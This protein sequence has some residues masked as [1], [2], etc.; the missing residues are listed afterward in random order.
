M[1]KH[2]LLLAAFGFVV[3]LGVA[4][5]VT[6]GNA[7]AEVRTWDGGGVDNNFA[8]AANWSDNTA[9]VNGDSIVLPYGV[10][11]SGC[12]GSTNYTLNNDLNASNVT[13]AGI[14]TTGNKPEGC[15]GN[16][17][18]DGN[19]VKVSGNIVGNSGGPY[20]FPWL[21]INAPIT[22]TSNLTIITV[23][24]DSSL[25]IGGNTVTLTNSSFE[26]GASGTGTLT[27]ASNLTGGAGGGCSD[28]AFSYPFGGDSSGFSGSVV[29]NSGGSLSVTSNA[30]DLA[31]AA[32]SITVN[33]GGWLW[34]GAS[35]GESYTFNK[36]ITFNGGNLGASQYTCGESSNTT[37]TLTGTLTLNQNIEVSLYRTN[38]HVT[39]TDGSGSLSMMPGLTG[40]AVLILP[41]GQQLT[42]PVET[43]VIDDSNKSS[44][45]F[46]PQGFTSAVPKNHRYVVNITCDG[47]ATTSTLVDGILAGNG[48]MTRSVLIRSGGTISPGQSP[49]T[50]TVGWLSFEEGGT[51]EFEVLSAEPGQYDQVVANGGVVLGNGTLNTVL[52]EGYNLSA[53]QQ[54]VIIN[55]TSS[56]PVDGTFK[57]L[58]EGANFEVDGVLFS[59]SYVG[60]DGNDVV[61]T[62]VNAPDAPDTGFALLANNPVAVLGASTV[63][64]GAILFIAR[65]YGLLA[66]I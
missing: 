64:A 6:S 51:Y 60:G 17:I 66:K 32:A 54:L 61:L 14:T 29:I 25:S 15:L 3:S 38:L 9:P 18:I 50:L 35:S 31:H 53:G 41:S 27:L 37:I 39:S 11:M 58:P 44:Y 24:S 28:T 52:L 12:S 8:T 33:N 62:V 49:G 2:K 22:A 34:F 63:C 26:G 46:S 56:N 42:S 47:N 59:I 65:R 55:N 20:T 40:T 48:S 5:G 13:L 19:E 30:N 7:F 4:L 45:C 21:T 1:K 23:R 10:I 16:V 57:D 36:P 43:I